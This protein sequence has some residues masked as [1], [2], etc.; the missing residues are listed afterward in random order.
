MQH[1][2]LVGRAV[3]GDVSELCPDW[4]DRS[5]EAAKCERRARAN[6]QP[7]P[8]SAHRAIANRVRDARWRDTRLMEARFEP[9]RARGA[10]E[11]AWAAYFEY[12]EPMLDA[13]AHVRVIPLESMTVTKRKSFEGLIG[14]GGFASWPEVGSRMMTRLVSGED[15]MG[16]WVVVQEGAYRY[17]VSQEGGLRVVS[18]LSRNISRPRFNG[19]TKIQRLLLLR[20][21]PLRPPRHKEPHSVHYPKRTLPI[22]L[23]L[24]Q[25]GK[26]GRLLEM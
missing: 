23:H 1:Q 24:R 19:R 9:N 11:R 5:R 17:S 4:L 13:P 21:K 25:S 18:V 15:M 16:E 10:E 26:T 2:L 7:T 6:Q 14:R 12:G 20:P 22:P 8:A 3:F